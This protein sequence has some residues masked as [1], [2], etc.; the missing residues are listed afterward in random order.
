MIIL[1]DI[2]NQYNG[3][4]L[5]KTVRMMLFIILQIVIICAIK[6]IIIYYL[7]YEF[8]NVYLCIFFNI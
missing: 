7:T 3:S 4:T 2:T 6:N 1:E 5:C 8:F